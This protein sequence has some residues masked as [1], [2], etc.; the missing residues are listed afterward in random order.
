MS[1]SVNFLPWRQ[2]RQR[3]RLRLACL[4]VTGVVLALLV[5]GASR[6]VES[7]LQEALLVC[8]ID[9]ERQLIRALTQREEH[10]RQQLEERALLQRQQATRQQTF[11]WQAR[12]VELAEQLPAQAWLTG[13]SYQKDVLSLSGVLARF[14]ALHSLDEQMQRIDGFGPA[15]AGKMARDKDGR[16]LFHYQMKRRVADVAP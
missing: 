15:I 4:I 5:A 12:L 8:R 9:A 7:R 1:A 13:L 2:S 10:F 6:Q 14:S 3:K 11:A 16:W